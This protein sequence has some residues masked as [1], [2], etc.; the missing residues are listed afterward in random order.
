M[1]LFCGLPCPCC[2]ITRASLSL[3]KL[4]F[5]QAFFLNPTVYLWIP[6]IIYLMWTRY[7]RAEGSSSLFSVVIGIC[8]V[9]IL[10]YFINMILYF[11]NMEPYTYYEE[12]FLH[13]LINK[14]KLL[15]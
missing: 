10:C 3:L 9:T 12:N 14:I 5:A 13:W 1:R 6:Y 4:Q 2:G 7:F 8:L 15:I 11:P